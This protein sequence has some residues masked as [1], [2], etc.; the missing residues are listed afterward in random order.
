M[1]LDLQN[2]SQLASRLSKNDNAPPKAEADKS[3]VGGKWAAPTVAA[4][5]GI[6]GL[7][8]KKDIGGIRA[9]GIK[10][11]ESVQK[12]SAS[13][14]G[15]LVD[16]VRKSDAYA[17]GGR[18]LIRSKVLGLPLP[19]V[20]NRGFQALATGPKSWPA[21]LSRPF[22]NARDRYHGWYETPRQR[23]QKG[24]SLSHHQVANNFLHDHYKKYFSKDLSDQDLKNYALFGN[25]WSNLSQGA[26]DALAVPGRSISGVIHQLRK[27]DP[28]AA[29]KLIETVKLNKSKFGGFGPGDGGLAQ[30]YIQDSARPLGIL[31]GMADA[32]AI[33]GLS[34]AGYLGLRNS[35]EQMQKDAATEGAAEK[36][37]STLRNLLLTALGT[38]TATSGVRELRNPLQVGFSWSEAAKHGDGHKNPGRAIRSI[39][40]DLVTTDPRFKNTALR[41]MTRTQHHGVRTEQFMGPKT[42]MLFDTGMGSASRWEWEK[43]PNDYIDGLK[44]HPDTFK[45]NG[46]RPRVRAGGY[47]G[48]MTDIGK[49]GDPADGYRHSIRTPL[50]R[51]MSM[52]GLKDNY[53]NWGP[54]D[55]AD[56]RSAGNM[57]ALGSDMNFRHL[58]SDGMPTI[59]PAATKA[60][61]W[62]NQAGREGIIAE[63]LKSDQ[64]SDAHKEILKNS[65]GKKIVSFTGSGRGDYVATR[66]RDFMRAARRNGTLDDYVIVAPTGES[67]ALSPAGK[68]LAKQKNVI[69]TGRLPQNLYVGLPAAS[70]L[71]SAST[72]TSGA[73]EALGTNTNLA[74]TKDWKALKERE[75]RVFLGRDSGRQ[76]ARRSR[77]W[78]GLSPSKWSEVTQGVNLDDWNAGNRDYMLRQ[79]GVTGVQTGDDMLR[80]LRQGG[81]SLNNLQSRGDLM[82]AASAAS[83]NNLKDTI[84]ELMQRSK[85]IKNFRGGAKVLGGL[86]LTAAGILPSL[87]NTKQPAAENKLNLLGGS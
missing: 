39:V 25:V 5:L 48:Y 61:D 43:T 15:A 45:L 77:Y 58:G 9:K 71:H 70:D 17:M 31:E 55:I 24:Q 42:D 50:R 28:Q 22:L 78:E 73:L 23:F 3:T 53:L 37:D 46:Q 2:L 12:P 57:S 81:A 83:K 30:K 29:K 85:T 56:Q 41:D 60:V 19:Y 10:W 26:R 65:E 33:G 59:T 44:E 69:V 27:E 32:T 16:G 72:G 76:S 13:G 38:G 6:A 1:N 82:R 63:A 7:K 34:T 11:L 18:D 52:A 75:N 79:K 84:A 40:E 8:A 14:A 86:G 62:T 64:L 36:G 80:A 47:V 35:N 49:L 67:G 51:L 74:V 21:M 20:A 68:W 4:L 87:L 66:V 54:K